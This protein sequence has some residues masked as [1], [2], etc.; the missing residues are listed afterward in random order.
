MKTNAR[1]KKMGSLSWK[2]GY[3]DNVED[4]TVLQDVQEKNHDSLEWNCLHAIA[5]RIVEEVQ[6][7]MQQWWN[8][9]DQRATFISQKIDRESEVD[10]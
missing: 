7:A 8:L 6:I 2:I 1:D 10:L 3:F 4:T 5:D 9:D